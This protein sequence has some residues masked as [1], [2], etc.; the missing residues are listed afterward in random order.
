MQYIDKG[1]SSSQ[2]AQNPERGRGGGT[3]GCLP[4]LYM[5]NNNASS[6]QASE[7]Q[8]SERKEEE[9]DGN[10]QTLHSSE[11]QSDTGRT[12]SHPNQDRGKSE[13]FPR[14]DKSR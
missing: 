7:G 1:R 3:E 8:A 4:G 10:L 14:E 9:A 13:S 2:A 12:D 5:D 11:N 6:S